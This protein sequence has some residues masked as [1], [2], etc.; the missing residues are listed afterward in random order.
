[1]T[2]STGPATIR[3]AGGEPVAL[4]LLREFVIGRDEGCALRIEDDSV[5]RRHAR[6]TGDDDGWRIEDLES[7][8]GTFI[9]RGTELVT[10][11]APTALANGD[12]VRIGTH[13][14]Q[15]SAAAGDRVAPES[16]QPWARPVNP[17]T[18]IAGFTHFFIGFYVWALVPVLAST[19]GADFGYSANTVKL[20]AATAIGGG[21][22]ARVLFGFLTDAR[23]P[24]F[25]GTLSLVAAIPPLLGLWLLGDTE[26]VV[27]ICV[28][29]LGVGVAGLPVSIPMTSQRT[30][31]EKRGVALGI[32]GA[33][34]LGL[35]A[36]ALLG[37]RLAK[38]FDS[39]QDVFGVALIPT[40]AAILIFVWGSRGAWTT[41]PPGE[42][43]RLVR[44]PPLWTVAI[45]YGVT[46]GVFTALFGFLP[47]VLT[48]G[49][50]DYGLTR[51]EAALVLAGGAFF[52]AVARPVGGALSDRFGAISVLPWVGL[53]GGTA[54]VLV[55]SA[56]TGLAIVL[57][58]LVMAVFD[59]G[60]GA[61][62]KLAAQRFG[63][64]LGAGAG[65]VGAVGSL[66]AFVAVQLLTVLLSSS[67]G[68]ELP[69]AV[70]SAAPIAL[71]AWMFVDARLRPSRPKAPVLPTAPHVQRLD[72]YGQP[73]ESIE[74]GDALTIGRAPGNRLLLYGDDL[75]SRRH[76]VI[77]PS[78][79]GWLVRDLGSTN[80]TMLWRGG[81]WARVTE[82]PLK[83]GDVL[84][85]GSQVLRTGGMK[86]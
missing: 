64:A 33:G 49:D 57:F 55:G 30:A 34:S 68:P 69:F 5:S 75:A 51:D 66:L 83:A 29:G 1:M 36:A 70:L 25:S 24:L 18:V 42:W 38:A 37:T 17:P 4:T 77:T 74:I 61:S 28:A 67:D 52:G 71:A 62:F 10:V 27:W 14:L 58:V 35:V 31:P 44:S 50:L 32:V 26:A 54:C 60:T 23:G 59:G 85:I 20:L 79:G 48:Q 56:G 22:I 7:A 81:R 9:E 12:V 3:I 86:E 82:E 16:A 53:I 84:V 8:N 6:I 46:F 78:D 40:A 43:G 13:R 45:I 39:W 65:I 73:V 63:A 2:D 72:L 76:A 80:G 15:F 11:S 47:S 41:P 19:I 21:A